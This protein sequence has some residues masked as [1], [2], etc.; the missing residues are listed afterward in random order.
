[1]QSLLGTI[2]WVRRM[3]GLTNEVLQPLFQL[4]RGDANL[5]SLRYLTPEAKQSLEDIS[6]AISNCQTMRR[7]PD[8]PAVLVVFRG[9]SQPYGVLGQL[10][11]QNKQFL[12]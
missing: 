2:N 11:D 12:L 5:A 6:K 9:Q 10:N 4:L 8:L 7:V 1:L 3:L